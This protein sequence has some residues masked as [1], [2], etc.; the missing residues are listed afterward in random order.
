M[1]G[2]N[3]I[4]PSCTVYHNEHRMESPKSSLLIGFIQF[5]KHCTYLDDTRKYS[6][7]PM[8]FPYVMCCTVSVSS[9]WCVS[10]MQHEHT[11]PHTCTNVQWTRSCGTDESLAG[12]WPLL[13]KPLL[14]C[15]PNNQPQAAFVWS[16]LH[17]C[18]QVSTCQRPGKTQTSNT[19]QR[20]TLLI[21]VQNHR[22]LNSTLSS[23]F[24]NSVR[25]E[26]EKLIRFFLKH[27][28]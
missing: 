16:M 6:V 25:T 22:S 1:Q 4:N 23:H 20:R 14:Q 7:L 3:I 15:N 21:P 11:L 5:N 8:I 28:T 27:Y 2:V 17:F 9:P 13:S 26:Q 19:N 18:K 10:W 24:T 12:L